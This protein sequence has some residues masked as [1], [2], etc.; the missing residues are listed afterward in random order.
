MHSPFRIVTGFVT[1]PLR[2]GTAQIAM[3]VTVGVCVA[4]VTQAI[5]PEHRSATTTEVRRDALAVVPQADR[6]PKSEVTVP[7]ASID[8]TEA[9]SWLR[10]D[11]A[12]SETHVAKL[13]AIEPKADYN[14]PAQLDGPHP[15]TPPM[16]SN[17][18][19]PAP[20]IANYEPTMSADAP[21]PPIAGV[22][23]ALRPPAD[24]GAPDQPM[25]LS[26]AA[27]NFAADDF[28]AGT[29]APQVERRAPALALPFAAVEE[30]VFRLGDVV[31]S[32]GKPDRRY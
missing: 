20:T 17:E 25:V 1:G 13:R 31:A 10:T 12:V 16:V 5:L 19:A 3:S 6:L 15:Y 24:I 14:A 26:G 4:V 22:D 23:D 32:I 18:M 11:A 29:P 28:D 2:R 8:V 27:E 9:A 7:V 30:S 21:P